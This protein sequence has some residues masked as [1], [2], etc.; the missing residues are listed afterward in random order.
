MTFWTIAAVLLLLL[1]L[2]AGWFLTLVGMPGNWLMVLAAA[3]YRVW[4]PQE[5]RIALATS[6]VIVLLSLAIL[7]EILEFVLGAVTATRAGGGRRAAVG[8]LAGGMAGAIG[9]MFVGIP[10][11]IIG[12]LISAVLFAA[13]GAMV[14]AYLAQSSMREWQEQQKAWTIG[15]AAFWGRLGGTVAKL[16]VG[17]V[18]VVLALAAVALE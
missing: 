12:S 5:E 3:I 16:G 2:L 1:A 18:M 4:G 6:T 14:G 7:G 9:G 8:A 11:P 13:F 10:I 17:T 15:K